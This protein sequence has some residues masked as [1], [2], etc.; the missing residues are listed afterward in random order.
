M[1]ADSN[2]LKDL[3]H[4]NGQTHVVEGT[5]LPDL[6]RREVELRPCTESTTQST[7]ECEKNAQQGVG[8][9]PNR[10]FSRILFAGGFST[11]VYR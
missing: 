8:N 9:R 5:L 10:F 7:R 1:R 11:S 6:H 4:V 3:L 2:A